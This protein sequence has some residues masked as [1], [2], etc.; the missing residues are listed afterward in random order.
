MSYRD[1][2]RPRKKT[3]LSGCFE[4]RV[5][6]PSYILIKIRY[7][8]QLFFLFQ[9]IEPLIVGHFSVLI[10]K[11]WRNSFEVFIYI[12]KHARVQKRQTTR[13]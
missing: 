4:G 8:P 9:L 12:V 1:Y 11:P 7:E 2:S 6:G 10:E 5:F 3:Q 13:G